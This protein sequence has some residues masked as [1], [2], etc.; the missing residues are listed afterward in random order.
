MKFLNI[1]RKVAKFLL[2][3]PKQLT[4]CSDNSTE[5][6]PIILL[7][8]LQNLGKFKKN[9]ANFLGTTY[10]I[11]VKFCKILTMEGTQSKNS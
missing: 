2:N 11:Y 5:Q 9:F 10:E 6:E 7:Q 8:T 1:R 4:S 3:F